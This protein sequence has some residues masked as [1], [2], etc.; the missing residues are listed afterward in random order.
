MIQWYPTLVASSANGL[1][2]KHTPTK[3]SLIVCH[4]GAEFLRF[5]MFNYMY[6]FGNQLLKD[7]P[8]DRCYFEVIQGN[9]CQ[10][11][12]FDIDISVSEA[13]DFKVIEEKSLSLI[14]AIKKSI[15]FDDR[16][17]ENN[18][19]VFSSHG[20]SKLSYHIIIDK[21]C[22]PDYV[23]NKV[24]CNKVINR[25]L[26]PYKKHIDLLVYTPGRQFRTYGSTKRGR[27][28]TKILVGQKFGENYRKEFLT[29]LMQ[30]LISNTGSCKVLEHSLPT[31]RVFTG[32]AEDLTD[33]ELSVIESLDF[34]KDGTYEISDIKVRLISLKRTRTSYCEI[35]KR[36]HENENPYLIFG[37]DEIYL[38]CRR[39]GE[40]RV[41]IWTK[42]DSMLESIVEE[43]SKEIESTPEKKS[44][45]KTSKFIKKFLG[46]K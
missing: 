44:I 43:T 11:P 18:I 36:D 20:T 13:E 45:V 46:K 37:K 14:R 40:D 8:S 35:C 34:I 29:T 28:R 4:Q 30:S 21:W 25:V 17:S 24:Y 16:I 15:L 22:L 5:G 7:K 10:K 6:Q 33:E 38:H 1:L 19:L 39:S 41:K 9:S 26:S 3:E 31:K 23:S 32:S 27:D 42:P 12:Y 2:R